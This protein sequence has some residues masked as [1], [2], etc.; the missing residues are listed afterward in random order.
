MKICCILLPNIWDCHKLSGRAELKT[1]KR[2]NPTFSIIFWMQMSSSS[3]IGMWPPRKLQQSIFFSLLY[4]DVSFSFFLAFF[5][6]AMYKLF[7]RTNGRSDRPSYRGA[8]S[9]LKTCILL[10]FCFKELKPTRISPRIVLRY[11]AL[12]FWLMP[13][14]SP[15]FWKSTCRRRW[16]AKRPSTWKS[17]M[18][19]SGDTCCMY[20]NFYDKFRFSFSLRSRMITSLYEGRYLFSLRSRV[21]VWKGNNITLIIL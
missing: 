1:W 3:C 5:F 20:S 21:S 4:F 11:M 7:S 19:M 15:G 10:H 18:V 6:T 9:H 16:L 2:Q 12:T 17:V 13:I 8:S 14:W